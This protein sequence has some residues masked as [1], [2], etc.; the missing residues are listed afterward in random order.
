[1]DTPASTFYAGL[2]AGSLWD[3]VSWAHHFLILPSFSGVPDNQPPPQN[4]RRTLNSLPLRNPFITAGKYQWQ[5]AIDLF[6]LLQGCRC[7]VS[8]EWTPVQPL[9][10]QIEIK[11]FMGTCQVLIHRDLCDLLPTFPAHV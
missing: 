2:C 7:G 10:F 9:G 3:T 4:V 8:R 5:G 6:G 11:Q 1:M